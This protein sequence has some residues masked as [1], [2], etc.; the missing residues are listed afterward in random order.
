MCSCPIDIGQKSNEVV[1]GRG[2][3]AGFGMRTLARLFEPSPGVDIS[4]G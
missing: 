3:F 2:G 4:T 1:R